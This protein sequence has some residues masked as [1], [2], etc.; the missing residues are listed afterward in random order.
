M[1]T[2]LKLKLLFNDRA[3][4]L[5][6][7]ATLMAGEHFNIAAIDVER[8]DGKAT[9]YLEAE[10]EE[11]ARER[12]VGKIGSLPDLLEISTIQTLPHEKREKR[13]QILLDSV[14]DGIFFIDEEGSIVLINRVAQ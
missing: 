8:Q 12:V 10:G 11:S 7:L 1:E 4:V 9:L 13:M 6:S 2:N 14:S 3:G 5:A